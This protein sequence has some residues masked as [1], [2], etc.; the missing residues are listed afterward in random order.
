MLNLQNECTDLNLGASISGVNAST[1]GYCDK[2]GKKLRGVFTLYTDL[3]FCQ[4]IFRYHLDLVYILFLSPN[5]L[6][7]DFLNTYIMFFNKFVGFSYNIGHAS[8]NG[9]SVIFF[10]CV[11][12]FLSWSTSLYHMRFKE[13]KLHIK[14]LFF[15]YIPIH[16]CPHFFVEHTEG[17]NCE[18]THMGIKKFSKILPLLEPLH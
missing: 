11:E 15:N 5:F 17:H 6:R 8:F 9:L 12:Q 14:N 1:I 18:M 4:S 7:T 2:S 10:I 3:V 16:L 13:N